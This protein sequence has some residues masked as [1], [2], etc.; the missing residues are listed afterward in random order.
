[1]IS[2]DG[3][4]FEI[5]RV[6]TSINQPI[7]LRCAVLKAS[8]EQR[9]HCPTLQRRVR[10]LPRITAA[11]PPVWRFRGCDVTSWQVATEGAGTT[12]EELGESTSQRRLPHSRETLSDRA[13]RTPFFSF[14]FVYGDASPCVSHMQLRQFLEL[15]CPVMPLS[16]DSC[17]QEKT[18]LTLKQR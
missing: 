4:P 3:F 9:L 10:R 16:W 13:R 11:L 7:H 8:A 12:G 14:S 2:K 15:A 6:Q 17:C 18:A 5:W 1:M